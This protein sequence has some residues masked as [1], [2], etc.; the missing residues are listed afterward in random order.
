MLV[1]LKLDAGGNLVLRT[2]TNRGGHEVVIEHVDQL[3]HMLQARQQKI[4]KTGKR[5]KLGE[6]G[7]ES[8]AQI[9]AWLKSN[10]VTVCPAGQTSK[11][12]SSSAGRKPSSVEEI[13]AGLQAKLEKLGVEI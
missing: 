7:A 6:P 11:P 3:I 10:E 1:D 5:P 13:M 2:P 9:D 12:L 8:Q 4:S